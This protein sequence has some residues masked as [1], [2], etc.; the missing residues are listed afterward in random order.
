L[1]SALSLQVQGSL[2]ILGEVPLRAELHTLAEG[3]GVEGRVW[4]GGI[5]DLAGTMSEVASTTPC[6]AP[7]CAALPEND[8]AYVA[9]RYR[10]L[11]SAQI[12]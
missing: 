2:V 1:I 6:A 10:A 7:C 9:A 3:L 5:E 8:A 12:D 11:F 4:S